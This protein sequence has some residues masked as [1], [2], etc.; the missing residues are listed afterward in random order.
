MYWSIY[1][2]VQQ[3]KKLRT[4]AKHEV[5]SYEKQPFFPLACICIHTEI[6]KVATI[7]S[8]LR[9]LFFG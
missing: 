9:S 5:T 2:I 8:S 4:K 1:R 7:S 3:K 6:Q